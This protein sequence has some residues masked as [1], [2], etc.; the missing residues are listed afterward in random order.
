MARFGGLYEDRSLPLTADINLINLV[1]VAFTLLVIF[2]ITAPILQ[3]GVEVQI[4]KAEV[5]PIPASDAIVVT[6]DREGVV[7]IDDASV[8]LDE[9]KAVIRDVWTQ[10][11][12]PAVYVRGDEAAAYG[13]VLKV[14]AALKA[15]EIEAVGLVAEP[16]V[17]RRR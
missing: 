4:P 8:T 5:A 14:I 11:G 16:E 15:A 3:G 10:R 2:M 12:T 17:G 1:D 7:Y 6:V 9:F 13:I